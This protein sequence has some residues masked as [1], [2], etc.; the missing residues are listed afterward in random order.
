MIEYESFRAA[1]GVFSVH[2]QRLAPELSMDFAAGVRHSDGF[3]LDQIR[4]VRL[5]E[6]W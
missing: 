6:L 2:V 1:W 5:D 4:N 3:K